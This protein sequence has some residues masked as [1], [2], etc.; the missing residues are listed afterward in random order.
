MICIS[1][2]ASVWLTI[3]LRNAAH[4]AVRGACCNATRRG[5]T[6]RTT[7]SASSAVILVCPRA[8]LCSAR[9]ALL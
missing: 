6:Q 1:L 5:A 4:G 7:C 9:S 3:S 8:L 2:A